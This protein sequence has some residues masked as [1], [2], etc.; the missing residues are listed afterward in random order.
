[1]KTNKFFFLIEQ[2]AFL[3]GFFLLL[4]VV[5]ILLSL[6]GIVY[7]YLNSK[8]KERLALIEKGM[9]PNLAR[10]DFLTQLVIIGG[11]FSSG[12]ILGDKIPGEY[13]PLIGVLI[14][15]IAL[16]TFTIYKRNK[17]RRDF[18]KNND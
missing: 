4:L 18:P 7:L 6:V 16:V 8:T 9:D 15:S 3:S 13:G 2:P 1:M 12:L 14:A 11:G 10:S 5:L 17:A